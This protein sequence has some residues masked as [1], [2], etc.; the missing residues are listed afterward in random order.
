MKKGQGT[1][2]DEYSNG[3]KV[4]SGV[5]GRPLPYITVMVPIQFCGGSWAY[6]Y[7]RLTP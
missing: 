4:R 1:M 2:G 5:N 6:R 7:L 3:M